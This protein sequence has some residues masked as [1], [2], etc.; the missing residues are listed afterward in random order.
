M[1]LTALSCWDF[2]C[3]QGRPAEKVSVRSRTP[4]ARVGEKVVPLLYAQSRADEMRYKGG[5]QVHM[6]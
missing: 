5:G 6:D 4:G 2:L 1:E 3:A